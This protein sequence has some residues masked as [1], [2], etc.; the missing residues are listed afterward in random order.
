[1]IKELIKL[2]N[3]LDAKGL[4][5]EADALDEIIREAQKLPEA[6]GK[7]PDESHDTDS[8]KY[9]VWYDD[10][11]TMIETPSG[12]RY[13]KGWGLGTASSPTLHSGMDSE[14]GTKVYEAIM[15]HQKSGTW[16]D[17]G[18]TKA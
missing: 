9:H 10:T 2:A 3:E 16:P 4:A 17:S 12:D 7:E 13:N 5:K 11:H 14:I 6:F 1:M 8:G 18:Y 15:T